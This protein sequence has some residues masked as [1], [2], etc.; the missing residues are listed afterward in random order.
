MTFVFGVLGLVITFA[1]IIQDNR[2][3]VLTGMILCVVAFLSREKG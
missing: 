1:G 3:M 2:A